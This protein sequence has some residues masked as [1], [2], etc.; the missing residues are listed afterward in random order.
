MDPANT[1]SLLQEAEKLGIYA[2]RN[3]K[4]PEDS[5]IFEVVNSMGSALERGEHPSPSPLIAEITK[6]SN[7]TGL[8]IRQLVRRETPI[9]QFRLWAAQL[10][11]FLLGFMTLLLTLYLTFQSSQL[12]KADLAL[13]ENQDL[14]SERPQEKI[15]LA[16]KMYKYESVLNVKELPLAQL[17]NYQKLVEEAKRLYIK[18]TAVQLL[19]TDASVIRYVPEWMERAGP[20]WF[21]NLARNLN[22]PGTG[23]GDLPSTALDRSPANGSAAS[24]P[25]EKG[26]QEAQLTPIDCSVLPVAPS[27]GKAKQ[28]ASSS[29]S[30]LDNYVQSFA[31]FM[32]SL[33]IVEDGYPTDP[34][35][36]A[37]RNKVHLLVAWLLPGLYGLLGACVFVMRDLLRDHGSSSKVG[38]DARIVDLLTLLLRVALGGLAGIIIGWFSVPTSP[39]TSSVAVNIS[40]IPFGLAFLA[41]FS[42]ESLF[43]LLDR[44]NKTIGQQDEKEKKS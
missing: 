10:T 34:S 15:Y 28:A 30:D 20:Q 2:A 21:Q 41:G 14:V 44:L 22:N 27:D 9:G 4:L 33:Q 8:T 5:R 24:N 19:L 23:N 1:K 18:R 36:Y 32:Q 12:H 3:G 31:C 29:K 35:I 40:S 16:W 26:L 7:A 25:E 38:S 42:I 17:D 11:P 39:I 13:R 43:T 6:V 37:T